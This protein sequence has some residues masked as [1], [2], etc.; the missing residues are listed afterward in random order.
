MQLEN[1]ENNWVTFEKL[2]KRLT[3]DC[4]KNLLENVGERL[5][6]CP[7]SAREDQGGAYPGGLIEHLLEVTAT[8]RTLNKALDLKIPVKQ[9]LK[10]G[11]LH[12]IGKVGRSR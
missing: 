6:M 12:E 3:D 8:M 5:V 4:V 1:L 11:L 2:C 7:L 10:V 9:V